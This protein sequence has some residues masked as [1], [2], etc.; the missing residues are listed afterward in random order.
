MGWAG[1]GD[2]AALMSVRAGEGKGRRGGRGGGKGSV[3]SHKFSEGER[4]EMR[5]GRS[6][7]CL[8]KDPNCGTSKGWFSLV[9]EEEE[10]RE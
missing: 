5:E 9:R 4:R 3:E 10:E 8:P 2:L 6:E 1:Q 7:T